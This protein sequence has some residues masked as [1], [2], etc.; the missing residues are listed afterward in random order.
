MSSIKRVAVV[1]DSDDTA[2]TM[3]NVLEDGE[4][5]AYRQGHAGTIEELVDQIVRNSDAAVCDHRLRYGGF[6]DISGADLA[7]RLIQREHPAILVTQYLD[8]DASIAIRRFR[9]YLPVVLKRENADEPEELRSAFARCILEISKG[10]GDNRKPQRTL[11]R[12]ADMMSIDGDV[13][14]DALV[15][16]FSSKDAVRFP[17]SLVHADDRGRVVNGVTLTALTNLRAEE[18][19]DLY[20]EDVRLS[21]EP[22]AN[23]GLE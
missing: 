23:D 17:L 2:T 11:L 18:Q 7:S 9:Q 16:G 1:D 4:F 8:Q 3:I 10:R 14:I 22:D 12:V 6:Q 13:V 21:D 5:D 15:D 19:V 20:F